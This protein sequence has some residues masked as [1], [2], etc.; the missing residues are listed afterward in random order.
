M[1]LIEEDGHWKELE[2]LVSLA[3]EIYFGNV[4]NWLDMT[5]K[6][7]KKDLPRLVSLPFDVALVEWVDNRTLGEND[8]RA[9][10]P[11]RA[12]LIH[13]KP[14]LEEQTFYDF[15]HTWNIDI[16]D[17]P[18][19][20][21]NKEEYRE[22]VASKAACTYSNNKEEEFVDWNNIKHGAITEFMFNFIAQEDE[23]DF[24]VAKLLLSKEYHKPEK[25]MGG[26][27]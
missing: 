3:P 14:E 26:S 18:F 17:V 12:V 7:A 27:K 23:Y 9:L 22:W 25:A 6:Y 2:N 8:I 16:S 19:D 1:S 4:E 11:K 13:S 5:K 10:A 15:Y 21:R 20:D 24:I